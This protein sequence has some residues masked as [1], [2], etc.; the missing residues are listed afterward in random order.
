MR[1]YGFCHQ[2][3][4]PL[5][6]G[7]QSAHS[8]AEML[9]QFD[10]DSYQNKMAREW[11]IE[12]KTNVYLNGGNCATLQSLYD[13]FVELKAEGM[14]YPFVKFHEDE[15][16]LNNALTSVAIILPEEIYQLASDIKTG[17]VTEYDE[18][19]WKV[20][21]ALRNSSYPLAN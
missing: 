3:L 17:I 5:Q 12:H 21:L 13:F 15:A 6:K 16:S 11:A 7:L 10:P 18:N 9:V 8:T 2:W 14:P 19:D 20:K 1:F 4:S